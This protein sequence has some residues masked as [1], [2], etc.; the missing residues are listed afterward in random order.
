MAPDSGSRRAVQTLPVDGKTLISAHRGGADLW[1][2]NSLTAFRHARDLP[3]ESVE[4]DV[5]PT[6]DG[7]LVV[8][9]DARLGRMVAG[10]EALCDMAWADL[11]ARRFLAHPEERVPL[12]EELLVMHH[13]PI[14]HCGWS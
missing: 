14:S 12:L 3:V 1:P 11:K 5:H 7:R 4:F 2:E 9:H 13:E 10:E 6:A 8:H